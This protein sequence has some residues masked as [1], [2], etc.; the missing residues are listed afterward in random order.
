[1]QLDL[2][3]FSGIGLAQI[4]DGNGDGDLFAARSFAFGPAAEA[5][6]N[7]WRPEPPFRYQAVCRQPTV[8]RAGSVAVEIGNITTHNRPKLGDIEIGVFELKGIERP[9]DQLYAA[10]KSIVALRKLQ[11]EANAAVLVFRKHGKQMGVEVSL[12]FAKSRKGQGEPYRHVSVKGCEN[13]PT[14]L[15]GNDEDVVRNRLELGIAPD[16]S[17]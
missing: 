17:L 10:S 13:L 8:E 15:G 11:A 7:A 14:G 4:L 1:V 2:L 16:Y 9:L 12:A 3:G 5:A 6:L